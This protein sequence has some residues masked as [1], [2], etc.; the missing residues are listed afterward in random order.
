MGF[1]YLASMSALEALLLLFAI[2]YADASSTI[3]GTAKLPRSDRL[4]LRSP[5]FQKDDF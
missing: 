1:T 2:A 5:Q 3:N 4:V